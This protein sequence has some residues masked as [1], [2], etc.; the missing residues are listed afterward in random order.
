MVWSPWSPYL[1][2]ERSLG[3]PDNYPFLSLS[4]L[5]I[6]DF[7]GK[8]IQVPIAGVECRSSFRDYMHLVTLRICKSTPDLAVIHLEMREISMV[9]ALHAPERFIFFILTQICL[10]P[11]QTRELL[12]L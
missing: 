2:R 5:G 9:K 3:Q 12:Q 8:K 10:F 11:D 7:L 4:L 1:P 6:K